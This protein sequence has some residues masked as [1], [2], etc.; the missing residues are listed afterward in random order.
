VKVGSEIAGKNFGIDIDFYVPSK[1]DPAWQIRKLE[2][3]ISDSIDG[4]AVAASD[5]KSITSLMSGIVK[6]DIPCIAIDS[7]VPKGRHVYIGTR[8]YY[9]GQQSAEAMLELL[10][11]ESEI[12]IITD[13]SVPDF[14]QS[15]Q[16]FKD[17]FAENNGFKISKILEKDYRTIQPEDI[18]TWIGN[19]RANLEINGIF[20]VSDSIGLATAKTIEKMGKSGQIKIVC[21][22]ES[23]EI[24]KLVKQDIVQVAISRRP[25]RLG[26]SSVIVLQN[27]IKAG[28]RDTLMILPKSEMIELGVVTVTPSNIDDYRKQLLK[29]GIKTEF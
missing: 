23:M 9:A 25:Y 26:Y 11:P 13:P 4:V 15:V 22:G 18:E 14:L 16:G 29:W 3:V 10:D 6:S 21:I 8:H 27:M 17:M 24:M 28:I 5:P 2:Q 1:D 19:S 12:G 20:C 7:D